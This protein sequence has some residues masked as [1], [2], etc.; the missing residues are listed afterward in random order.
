MTVLSAA[1]EAGTDPAFGKSHR[2]GLKSGQLRPLARPRIGR[3][4]PDANRQQLRRPRLAARIEQTLQVQP[5]PG[6]QKVRVEIVPPRNDRHR[7]T[8]DKR[9]GCEFQFKPPSVVEISR[10]RKTSNGSHRGKLST[11]FHG[12]N[13]VRAL[14]A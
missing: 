1:L 12:W 9:V 13:S 8:L 6:E 7:S 10:G 11:G 14:V 5:P 4:R 3:F 2:G